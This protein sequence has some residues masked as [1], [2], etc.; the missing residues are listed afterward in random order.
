MRKTEIQH[1]KVAIRQ[2][3]KL[4]YKDTNYSSFKAQCI[5][6]MKV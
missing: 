6:V 4:D 2:I 3:Q 1:F 5:Q